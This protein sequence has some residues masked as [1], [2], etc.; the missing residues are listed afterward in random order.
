MVE[1][2]GKRLILSYLFVVVLF[3]CKEGAVK[4][5]A[6][7]QGRV[8][9]QIKQGV[10]QQLIGAHRGKIKQKSKKNELYNDHIIF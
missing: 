2:I 9:F 7:I 8:L 3:T 6:R 10:F 5:K 1:S 4:G